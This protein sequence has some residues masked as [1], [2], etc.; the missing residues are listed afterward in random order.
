MNVQCHACIGGKSISEDVRRLD[1]GVHIDHGKFFFCLEL[2][3]QAPKGNGSCA[4]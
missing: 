3:V 4:Y 1:Y 2:S